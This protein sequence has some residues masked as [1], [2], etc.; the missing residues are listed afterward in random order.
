MRALLW[1]LLFL[2]PWGCV[3]VDSL[4]RSAVRHDVRAEHL[5]EM[6]DGAGAARES[7]RADS[8]HAA[9]QRLAESR[10]PWVNDL[11]LR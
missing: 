6:G 3:T 2:P 11:L 4:E 10:G 9:A 1:F 8:D 5:A 7:N